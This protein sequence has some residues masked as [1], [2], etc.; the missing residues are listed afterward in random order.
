MVSLCMDVGLAEL[1][2]HLVTLFPRLDHND[3][4]QTGYL[5]LR[6]SWYSVCVLYGSGQGFW[7]FFTVEI[8]NFFVSVYNQIAIEIISS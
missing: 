5:N 3:Q 6:Y 1:H 4:P 2:G 8:I 7:L